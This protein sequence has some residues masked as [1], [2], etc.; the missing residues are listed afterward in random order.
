MGGLWDPHTT[1]NTQRLEMV[2]R[3]A[4]R[5]VVNN[6]K[7]RHGPNTTSVTDIL[8]Q[9]NWITLAE[10]RKQA[11]LILLYKIAH[12]LV[13]V[14]IEQHLVKLSQTRV[15]R[16]ANPYQYAVPD[17]RVDYHRFAYFPRTARDWNSLPPHI[18]AAPT[19]D[20]F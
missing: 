4:A 20:A 14:N 16:A 9:L 3:G 17:S 12:N 18:V 7:Y 19:L 8:H 6:N 15:T 2:Q 13:A 10:R 1:S 11:R 5:W